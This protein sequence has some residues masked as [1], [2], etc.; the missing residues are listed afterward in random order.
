MPEF[1]ILLEPRTLSCENGH[2]RTLTINLLIAIAHGR[3]HKQRAKKPFRSRGE[4]QS[5]EFEDE[6]DD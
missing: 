2:T 3:H 4:E 1:I 5:Q 6:L